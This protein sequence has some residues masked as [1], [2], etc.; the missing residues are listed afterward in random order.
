MHTIIQVLLIIL[1]ICT[2]LGS[3]LDQ[4]GRVINSLAS[5]DDALRNLLRKYTQWIVKKR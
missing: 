1:S 3:L 4:L 2:L 5:L